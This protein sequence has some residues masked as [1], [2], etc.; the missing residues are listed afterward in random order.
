M[1][2]RTF[3]L[4]I[5]ASFFLIVCA[6]AQQLALPNAG[7]DE[8][9]D[10][11]ASWTLSGGAGEWAV[12][13]E[14]QKALAVTG[15]GED[16]NYWKSDPLPFSPMRSYR[17]QFRARGVGAAG[18]TA[19][20]G[21]AFCN[22]DLGQ[23]SDAW[24]T[25]THYFTT[26]TE[27]DS[28][29]AWLRLG[30]FQVKGKIMF[31][32]C[33]IV[34]VQPIYLDQDGVLLGDG[35]SISGNS[36]TF[37][38]PFAQ[39]QTN[40]GRPLSGYHCR[41]NTN[42]WVFASNDQVTY[43]HF[44]AGRKHSAGTI[45][46]LVDPYHAGK[47]VVSADNGSGN[48]QE[49]GTIAAAGPQRFTL[50]ATLFPAERIAIRMLALPVEGNA[51]AVSLQVRGY[52]CRTTLDGPPLT[53]VGKTSILSIPA[54]D[55]R[56]QLEVTSLGAGIP[57]GRNIV[58]AQV[59]NTTSDAISA[60]P[61][62]TLARQGAQPAKFTQPMLI[63]VGA[64][65]LQLPYE[66]LGSGKY[67]LIF[68]LGD[69]IATRIEGQL[70]VPGLYDATFGEKLP[71]A[72]DVAQ[73]WWASSGWKVSMQ[74]SVPTA[75]SER[76]VIRAAKNE[77]EAAQLVVRP[78]VEIGGFTALG[79][80]L[81][82][83]GG[84]AIPDSHVNVLRVR[85]VQTERATD[86]STVVGQWPDPLPPAT[87][88]ITLAANTNQPLWVRVT[89][90]PGVPAGEYNGSVALRGNGY[91][92]DVPLRVEVFDF[93]LPTRP[94]CTTTFGFSPEL[95]FKYQRVNDPAQRRQVLDLYWKNF[96]AHRIAPYNPAPLDPIGVTWPNLEAYKSGA[97]TDVNTAFAPAFDWTAWD[98]AMSMALDKYG[99]NSFVV[100]V[101]GMG[102]GTF[103][104]RT[105][106]TLL[107]YP[108]NT[109]E[110]KAAFTNYHR[111]LQEHLRE[112]N[113]LERGYVY[114]FDEP[115][116]KDYDFVMNGFRKLKEAAPDI[117]RMLTE[118][119]EPALFG[120]PTIWCPISNAFDPAKA[121]ERRAQGD[122]FWWYICTG[123]KAPYCTL[124]LDH[125]SLELRVWLWQ[126]WQRKIDGI[127]VWQS[128]YWTSDAA[129]PDPNAPQD[130]YAD[131]MSWMSGY[132][133]G[134]GQKKPWGNGDGR[135]IY[136]PEAANGK[137]P[138]TILEGP[139]DSIRWEMLRDGVEDYEYLAILRRLIEEREKA[140][141]DVAQY[142]PLLE[143][144]A[145]I[146][147][148]MTEFTTDPA[149]IE[150]QRMAV[151]KAI[152]AVAKL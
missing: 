94:A 129:Y 122:K 87:T 136:P 107:G 119:P 19:I 8:G 14:T 120:G 74:R 54:A 64:S 71:S 11:P 28:D 97:S 25:Y 66:L 40:L 60:V 65:T 79:A 17:L 108:E 96:S 140:G 91:A 126:T 36:Y 114:W 47:L 127:L 103:H 48:W 113:W 18:G 5:F 124:F 73:L 133:T 46:L 29:N 110:Y 15:T 20:A 142:K 149:V 115:D 59:V 12:D 109:A 125:P 55:P 144:P 26:P 44:I 51:E 69:G 101:Q 21:P 141:K 147:T 138:E 146:T 22:R 63:A 106:P 67:D 89:V 143:V 80:A 10:Q 81:T 111:A 13:G 23:L 99:F 27:I 49:V 123:P 139:V 131:P 82:G 9:T 148:G 4:S 41:F 2:Y 75:A 50:P 100:P 90:P 39:T 7:F 130:P 117:P 1:P 86:G 31:D 61:T 152:E 6:R 30:Q 92:V 33:S 151:A 128:N 72:S 98:A 150:S 70:D 62:L 35:E 37:T 132:D 104:A 77:S 42:R 68:T 84:A 16:S 34:P 53:V 83:P 85:Y 88:P 76:I 118:Q 95:V 58:I 121:D 38:A 116:P 135:F 45:D 145:A 3:F 93:E 43:T 32:S 105:D 24:Q 78:N 102:G 57:G 112:R 137:Q 134:T 52:T 56:L